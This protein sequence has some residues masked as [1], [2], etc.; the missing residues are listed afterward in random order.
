MRGSSG[1]LCVLVSFRAEWRE[2][3]EGREGDLRKKM[4]C[5][6]MGCCASWVRTGLEEGRACFSMRAHVR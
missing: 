1:L 2:E 3:R 4:Y 5:R 6:I